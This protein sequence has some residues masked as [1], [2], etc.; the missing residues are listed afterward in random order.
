MSRLNTRAS[1]QTPSSVVPSSETLA[2]HGLKDF[3]IDVPPSSI[4]QSSL[5]GQAQL[6][7]VPVYPT[8]VPI[9][10]EDDRKVRLRWC[11]RGDVEVETNFRRTAQIIALDCCQP[12]TAYTLSRSRSHNGQGS[13]SI[14]SSSDKF[15]FSTEEQLRPARRA[16]KDKKIMAWWEDQYGLWLVTREEVLGDFVPLAQFWENMFASVEKGGN[17]TTGRNEKLTSKSVIVLAQLVC[18]FRVG[19]LLL[20]LGSRQYPTR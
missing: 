18:C 4:R 6:W 15:Q 20:V 16:G 17:L 2:A 5:T 1:A 13:G 11:P 3:E 19:R 10:S 12:S 8:L 14:I 7:P 9:H